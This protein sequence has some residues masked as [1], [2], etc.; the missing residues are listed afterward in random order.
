MTLPKNILKLMQQRA[1]LLMK[2]SKASAPLKLKMAAINLAISSKVEPLQKKINDLEAQILAAA[3]VEEES[4]FADQKKYE[5]AGQVLKQTSGKAI[6]VAKEAEGEEDDA[7]EE[8]V[9][10]ALESV[11]ENS[12]NKQLANDS[13]KIKATL[14]KQHIKANYDTNAEFYASLGIL[15]ETSTKITLAAA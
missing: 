14:N 3:K 2:H 7:A 6:T 13:I 4:L 11:S 10:L 8:R 12:E 15:H 5:H 9:I 1:T